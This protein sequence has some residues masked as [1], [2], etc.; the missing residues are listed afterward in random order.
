MAPS[1][2][3]ERL[4]SR[5]NA[6]PCTSQDRSGQSFSSLIIFVIL[7]LVAMLNA[8]YNVTPVKLV[9]RPKLAFLCYYLENT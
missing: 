5:V 6:L 3:L 9:L 1:S 8:S 2:S 7:F 4:L